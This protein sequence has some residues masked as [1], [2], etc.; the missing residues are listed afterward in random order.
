MVWLRDFRLGYT[1]NIF[2]FKEGRGISRWGERWS[3][4]DSVGGPYGHREHT[5]ARRS[6]RRPDGVSSPPSKSTTQGEKKRQL[7][8]CH[9][10]PARSGPGVTVSIH[11]DDAIRGPNGHGNHNRSRGPTGRPDGVSSPPSES[12]TQGKG[13]YRYR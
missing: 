13:T 5:R 4:N 10:A 8:S 2:F 6:T 12:T 3:I 11:D 9:P 1:K 7:R